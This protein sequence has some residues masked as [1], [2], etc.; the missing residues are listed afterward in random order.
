MS[1]NAEEINAEEA[2]KI[3]ADRFRQHVGMLFLAPHNQITSTSIRFNGTAAFI[4]TGS[5]KLIVTNDHVYR[6]FTELKQEEPELRMFV[7]G[8]SPNTIIEL[9]ETYLI[10]RGGKAADLAI[11]SLPNPLQLEEIGKTYFP[12]SLWPPQRPA[13]ETPAVIIRF[14]GVHRIPVG[15]NLQINLTVI[16]DKITSSSQRH[17]ILV[18]EDQAR[19]TVKLNAALDEL[20]P[21]GGMSGS[22]AFTVGPDDDATIVGFLYETGEGADA[23]VFAVHDDVITSQGKIDYGLIP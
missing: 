16:C 5:A 14:Q 19:T 2:T 17:L 15:T 4:D 12:A 23:M 21:L 22:P 1:A 8:S 10:D 3:L 9:S 6:R 13:P 18:D 20:G 11:F 7:T